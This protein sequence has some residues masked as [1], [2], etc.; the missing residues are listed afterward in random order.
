MT[1]SGDERPEAAQ[2]ESG[3]PDIEDY[4]IDFADLDDD[5]LEDVIDSTLSW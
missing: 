4:D 5:D 3:D 2:G 1:A